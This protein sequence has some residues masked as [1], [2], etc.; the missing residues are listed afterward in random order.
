MSQHKGAGADRLKIAVP[1]EH[2]VGFA[3]VVLGQYAGAIAAKLNK[4]VGIKFAVFNNSS[5]RIGGF[6]IF[7]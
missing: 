7:N 2:L 6:N 1:K 3:A 5:Q 4:I